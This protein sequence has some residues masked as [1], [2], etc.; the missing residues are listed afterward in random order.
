M[1]KQIL[2]GF[3][4]VNNDLLQ[5]VMHE[6]IFGHLLFQGANFL[7]QRSILMNKTLNFLAWLGF[8]EVSPRSVE[9]VELLA[10]CL[11]ILDNF[12]IIRLRCLGGGGLHLDLLGELILELLEHL[13]SVFEL[14]LESNLLL[15]EFRF[16]I[17]DLLVELLNYFV[18]GFKLRVVEFGKLLTI[19]L[20]LLHPVTNLA[21][22]GSARLLEHLEASSHHWAYLAPSSMASFIKLRLLLSNLFDLAFHLI[23]LRLHGHDMG[24]QLPDFLE[25]LV[26]P[27][28]FLL[29]T[30]FRL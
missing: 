5:A 4:L 19:L 17:L 21:D 25:V 7:A 23:D 27:F 29:Q 12:F 11:E 13:V 2:V 8:D 9:W 18:F 16:D 1:T 14:A 28:L 6:L 15:L 30:I 22:S 26:T 20:I 24:L 10:D 3:L